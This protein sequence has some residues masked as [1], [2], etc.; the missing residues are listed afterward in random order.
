L[1]LDD[2]KSFITEKNI[3][4]AESIK[5]DYDGSIGENCIVL[6]KNGSQPCDLAH[7]PTIQVTVKNTDLSV[8]RLV[9]EEIFKALYPDE[10]YQ[11]SIQINGKTMHVQVIKEPFYL[12]KDESGRHCYVFNVA[13]IHGD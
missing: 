2:L 6:W 4:D 8:S 13:I 5:F 10:Q 12:E 11:K 3:A 9:S 7:R 1:I